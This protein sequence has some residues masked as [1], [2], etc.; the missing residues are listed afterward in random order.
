MGEA[1][2]VWSL[3]HD[4]GVLFAAQYTDER[5]VGGDL[6]KGYG[7]RTDQLGVKTEASY[8]GAVLTLAYTRVG[9]GTDIQKPWSGNPGYTSAMVQSFDRAGEQAFLAN[10]SNSTGSPGTRSRTFA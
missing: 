2:Y 1:K 6:L 10:A 4:V 5:S 7:F 9:G 8:A 3:P